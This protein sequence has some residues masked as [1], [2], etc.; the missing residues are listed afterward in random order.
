MP[1]KVADSSSS[2]DE[3]EEVYHKTPVP[4][5]PA[6][7]TPIRQGSADNMLY[8]QEYCVLCI[9]STVPGKYSQQLI[10]TSR[11]VTLDDSET[12]TSSIHPIST[13]IVMPLL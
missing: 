2:D 11:D 6:V 13:F 8:F 5:K 3:E 10:S 12:T 9:A 7:V 1:P 4:Q